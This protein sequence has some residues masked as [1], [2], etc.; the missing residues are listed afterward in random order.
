MRRP[1]RFI[2]ARVLPRGWPDVLRQVSLFA[3][4]YVAYQVVR[5][6][7]N[8]GNGYKP[9]GDATRIIDLE[10]V[11]HVFIEPS[12]QAW[13]SNKHLLMD[14]ADWSYLNAHYV[15]TIGDVHQQMLV[16]GP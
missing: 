5:G 8:G 11:L 1:L 10:R 14:I 4:A 13:A 16:G 6:L 2:E 12:I 3:A 7:I 9:F 15:V